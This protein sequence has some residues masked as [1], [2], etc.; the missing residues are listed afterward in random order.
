MALR[1]ALQDTEVKLCTGSMAN[2]VLTWKGEPSGPMKSSSSNFM[3]EERQQM[4]LRCD[5][6]KLSGLFNENFEPYAAGASAE[7]K[8]AA[9]N[10]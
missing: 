9:S 1:R 4:G 5:G 6:E 10:V 7:V 8:A 2:N 3:N